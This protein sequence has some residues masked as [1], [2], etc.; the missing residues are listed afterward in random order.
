LGILLDV[1]RV[2]NKE[3]SRSLFTWELR[4]SDR[5]DAFPFVAHSLDE[6]MQGHKSY[7]ILLIGHEANVCRSS[8]MAISFLRKDQRHALSIGAIGGGVEVLAK[9]GLLNG[10]KA[11]AHFSIRESLAEKYSRIHFNDQPFTCE[12]EFFTCA[13]GLATVQFS[14]ELIRRYHSCALSELVEPQIIYSESRNVAFT[15]RSSVCARYGARNEKLI[16]AI[17]IVEN[18]G[19]KPLRS[20]HLAA[21]V[22]LSVRQVERLFRSYLGK[23]PKE[24]DR[25]VRLVRGKALLCHSDIS[26]Q[27]ISLICGFST[28]S[29][30]SHYYRQCFGVIPSVTRSTPSDNY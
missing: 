6:R 3:A 26:V 23:S 13:G 14:L 15:Q 4:T 27:E 22:G 19:D 8:S 24:F 25:G 10:R 21:A 11:S 9:M 17:S 2:A 7:I 30:F 18:M 1:L 20:A 28:P 12:S 29:K 5:A 16:K